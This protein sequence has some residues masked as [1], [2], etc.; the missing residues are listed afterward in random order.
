MDVFSK[1][2]RSEVMS[3]IKGRGNKST[4]RRMAA[5]LRAN[6]IS[7]WKLHPSD[8]PGRPDIFFPDL[9]TAVFLD[10]CFWHAC[11]K[12]FSKPAQNSSFWEKKIFG[13]VRRDRKVTRA[14][15]RRGIRV[16]RIWEHD[17]EKRTDT[18]ESVIKDLQSK[19][20][21]PCRVPSRRGQDSGAG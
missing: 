13:N 20:R 19:A 10:G 6:R 21:R 2:K 4:E 8:V 14:L 3:Q 18:L 16:I 11:R 1:K 17:L 12:C 7:G 15:G 5:I 9:R